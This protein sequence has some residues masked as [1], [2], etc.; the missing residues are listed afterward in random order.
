M[1]EILDRI[2]SFNQDDEDEEDDDDLKLLNDA[3]INEFNQFIKRG[4]LSFIDDIEI[5]VPW[6][7]SSI[8]WNIIKVDCFKGIP[9]KFLLYNLI[10][11]LF[12]YCD[13]T[14]YFNGDEIIIQ[15]LF[16]ILMD[17]DKTRFNCVQELVK[18]WKLMY[19]QGR[20][21]YVLVD[22]EYVLNDRKL[23]MAVLTDLHGKVQ[24][25]RVKRKVEFYTS[26]VDS[27]GVNNWRGREE[28]QM[29]REK[30]GR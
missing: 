15:D 17:G 23:I 7:Y 1:R 8:E 12:W 25:S 16:Y 14:R 28:I 18:S 21:D 22:V 10:A 24:G 9:S 29:Y 6:F 3:E 26:A 11:I 4:D 20:I 19:D 13:L 27:G 5:S 30:R 2:D